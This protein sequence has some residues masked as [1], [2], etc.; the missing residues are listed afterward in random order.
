VVDQRRRFIED[1]RLDV[2][3]LCELC[4][5][6]GISRPTAYLW[7]ERFEQEGLAGLTDRSHRVHSCPHATPAPVW[8]AVRQ[9]RHE[10]P[11]WGPK[12][13]LW[14]VAKRLD[15]ELPAPSTVAGWLKRN[16]LVARRRHRPQR[17][18][19]GK[20]LGQA[21]T[22]NGLW[23]IDFKGHFRTRDGRY[24]YPLTVVDAY[25]RYVLACHAL[26]HPTRALT[27]AALERLF[28]ERGLPERIRSDNG[29][30]FASLALARLSK[31]SAWWIRLGI[32]PELIEPGHPEQ[33]PRHE[34]MHRTLKDETT[35]PPAGTCRAQ[36]RRFNHWRQ[37]Y[38]EQRP[39]ES[40][41]QQ[42]PASLYRSSPRPYPARPAGPEY[43]GHFEVRRVS[44]NGGIR[45]ASHRVP[46][47]HS[48][49]EEYIGLE[50]VDDGLWDVYYYHCRLGRFNERLGRIIDDRGRAFRHTPRV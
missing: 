29:A 23:T 2:F 43:P 19:P 33:N 49:L 39:H 45:W 9:A 48:M 24:C 11:T 8:Q 44:R 32:T 35:R 38:N 25:S 3:S 17:P 26:L 27:M 22:P 50:P 47:S 37:E 18:H 16:G 36:Q 6:Y 10:H 15:E 40:L 21:T 30:P 20:P 14:L 12:K 31:L 1:V 42:P 41:R 34:R 5:R 28:R 46:V 7:M 13:L 4:R